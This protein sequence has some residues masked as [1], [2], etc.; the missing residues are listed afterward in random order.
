[1][2][3]F[4]LSL[5]FISSYA[6]VTGGQRYIVEKGDN[7]S[8]IAEKYRVSVSSISKANNLSNPNSLQ[9]G[10]VLS[11]PSSPYEAVDSSDLSRSL[12]AKG[13][14][15]SHYGM[16]RGRM[17]YGIDIA[18]RTGTEIISVDN[19][20]VIDSRYMKGFGNTV[21]IQN[22]NVV[23]L[24]GH[25]SKR[26][27]KKGDIVK[28]GETIGRM[29]ATGNATGPHLHF[30]VR[31]DKSPVNPLV[32]LRDDGYSIASSGSNIKMKK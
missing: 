24:Y 11:I 5:I 27:A 9:V 28:S 21:K 17:H 29:G 18:N 20:F 14:I 4:F 16:R 3:Y 6:C 30:E 15:T 12:P 1:M 13:K 8:F 10:Q 22:G 32:Y 19:G 25:L 2:K 31:V 7:L 23:Y 26:Y